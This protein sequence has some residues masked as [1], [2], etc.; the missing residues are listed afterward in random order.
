MGS[1]PLF[2]YMNKLHLKP[3]GVLG[4]LDASSDDE[5]DEEEETEKKAKG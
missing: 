1:F 3:E 5:A 2:K 4:M